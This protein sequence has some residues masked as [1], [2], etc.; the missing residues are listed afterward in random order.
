[1][2]GDIRLKILKLRL[3]INPDV[4]TKREVLAIADALKENKGLVDLEFR[5]GFRVNDETWEAIGASLAVLLL[6]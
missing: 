6:L 2:C 5:C 1:L 4:S 3:S